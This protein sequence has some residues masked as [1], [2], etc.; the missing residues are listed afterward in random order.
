MSNAKA[1]A[2]P[3]KRHKSPRYKG[4]TYRVLK[5][6]TRRYAYYHAGSWVTVAGGEKDA[7]TAQGDARGKAARGEAAV[8]PS[9]AVPCPARGRA[10]PVPCRTRP[11]DHGAPGLA[12]T[13]SRRRAPR[14]ALT[15]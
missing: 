15:A 4:I 12:L 11:G 10:A 2:D 9:K 7:L 3:F 5:D 14:S 13:P 1:S 6:G 8:R